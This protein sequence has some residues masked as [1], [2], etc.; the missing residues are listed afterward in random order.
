M[1]SSELSRSLSSLVEV[2]PG[3]RDRADVA[4]VEVSV[5]VWHKPLQLPF[6]FFTGPWEQQQC[7]EQ[8][9]GLQAIHRGHGGQADSNESSFPGGFHTGA[10]LLP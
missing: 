6:V 3:C 9:R 5:S 7:D 8:L 1:H 2:F 4:L 10:P